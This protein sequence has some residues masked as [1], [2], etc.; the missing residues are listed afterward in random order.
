MAFYTTLAWRQGISHDG[1]A[2]KPRPPQL[3][4]LW[5]LARELPAGGPRKAA[6]Q[7]TTFPPHGF[8][9]ARQ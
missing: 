5:P 6:S 9:A 4:I 7:G 8:D 3:Y 2:V 1:K